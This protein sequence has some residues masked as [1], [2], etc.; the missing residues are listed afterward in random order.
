MELDTMIKLAIVVGMILL[1]S[2]LLFTWLGPSFGTV[3]KPLP[4]A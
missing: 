1:G 3:L 2:Y 4:G